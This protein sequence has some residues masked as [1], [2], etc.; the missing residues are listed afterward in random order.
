MKKSPLQIVN[1][2]FGSKEKL[3]ETVQA[4]ADGGLWIERINKDKA[5]DNVSNRKL[6]HLHD[7][8]SAVKD[9][10]GSRDKLVAAVAKLEKR[11]GD[12]KHQETL[13]AMPTPRLW[14][15]Y[16]AAKSRN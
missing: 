16:Q 3:V 10:V 5:L 9:E 11:E 4:L 12:E 8:L 14:D 1:D 13:A 15:R 6:L 7:V 2:R